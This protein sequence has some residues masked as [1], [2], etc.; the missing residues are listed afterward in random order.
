MFRD[1][2]GHLAV[3][4]SLIDADGD[5]VWSKTIETTDPIPAEVG[6]NRY[7]WFTD[8]TVSG[9]LAIDNLT[10]GEVSGAVTEIADKA[11]GEGIADLAADGVIPFIDV[12]IGDNHVV[13]VTAGAA[14]ISEPSR[15][16]SAMPR[17]PTAKAR[18]PGASLSPTA[19][20]SILAQETA[21]TQVY[22]VT[23]DDGHGGTASQ[24]VT[25][26]ITGSNDAPPSPAPTA[27]PWSRTASRRRPAR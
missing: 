2:G 11:A 9:G 19:R 17:P 4:F 12:D 27:A 16:W 18:S 3:D 22:T 15:R 10:L 1:V 8:V 14:A 23:V 5:I 21:L 6:G 24:D 26:T 20:W 13:S 25:V 7:G